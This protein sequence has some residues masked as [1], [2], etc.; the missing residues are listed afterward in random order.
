MGGKLAHHSVAHHRDQVVLLIE[1][2]LAIFCAPLILLTPVISA[3]AE[4]A[5]GYEPDQEHDSALQVPKLII[6]QPQVRQNLLDDDE[7]QEDVEEGREVDAEALSES[8]GDAIKPISRG[9]LAP[10]I[11]IGSR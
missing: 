3:K 6:I 10:G 9:V 5:H 11:L 8:I 4:D 1:L 2:S 7:E